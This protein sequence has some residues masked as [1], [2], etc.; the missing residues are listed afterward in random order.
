MPTSDPDYYAIIS[1]GTVEE[2]AAKR[3]DDDPLGILA[4]E[5]VASTDEEA[6]FK[7]AVRAYISKTDQQRRRH[8]IAVLAGAFRV[9]RSELKR[10]LRYWGLVN[11]SD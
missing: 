6:V 3:S 1:R 11:E 10:L 9:D 2:M 7:R 5:M 4:R 8:A